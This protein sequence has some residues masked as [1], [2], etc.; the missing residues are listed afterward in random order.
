MRRVAG[1]GTPRA[2]GLDGLRVASGE[3]LELRGQLGLPRLLGGKLLHQLLA[4][5]LRTVMAAAACGACAPSPRGPWTPRRCR[6]PARPSSRPG[7]CTAPRT[8]PACA[9]ATHGGAGWLAGLDAPWLWPCWGSSRSSRTSRP[10]PCRPGH[11]RPGCAGR[12]RWPW[13]LRRA[14]RA[15]VL[16]EAHALMPFSFATRFSI[17]LRQKT[18][19]CAAWVGAPWSASATP[20]RRRSPSCA[21]ASRLRT[22]P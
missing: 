11:R 5:L 14:Q 18:S 17:S 20:F 4:A 13:P 6:R 19:F 22:R 9:S 1:G 21:C 8:P 16:P 3:L 7:R 10:C 2:L 12:P 15:V